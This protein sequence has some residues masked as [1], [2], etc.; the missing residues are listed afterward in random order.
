MLR[1]TGLLT[2]D[3]DGRFWRYRADPDAVR[4]TA[5]ALDRLVGAAAGQA[6]DRAT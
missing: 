5:R 6:G 2:L 1:K 3:R 4:A